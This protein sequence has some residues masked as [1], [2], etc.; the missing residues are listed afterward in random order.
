M[1]TIAELTAKFTADLQTLRHEIA[2]VQQH[3][4]E[5]QTMLLKTQGALEA[6]ALL[7]SGQGPPTERCAD[8]QDEGESQ[9]G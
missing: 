7:D 9:A 8:A 2:D 5:R 3:L 4:A 1:T 6:L